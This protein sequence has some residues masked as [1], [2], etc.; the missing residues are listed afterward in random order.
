MRLGQSVTYS[1]SIKYCFECYKPVA[2]SCEYKDLLLQRSMP[3]TP[4]FVRRVSL[5]DEKRPGRCIE[6]RYFKNN[7]DSDQVVKKPTVLYVPGFMSH[8][9][10]MK[11]EHLSEFCARKCYNFVSY[12]PEGEAELT[13]SKYKNQRQLISNKEILDFSFISKVK[14]TS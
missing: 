3:P 4:T 2:L 1:N 14:E 12:D 13:F 5:N 11:S 8:G 6:V 10:A 7:R 9:K